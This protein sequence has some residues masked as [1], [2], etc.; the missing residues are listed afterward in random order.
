MPLTNDDVQMICNRFE[1]IL[2]WSQ[3]RFQNNF[4]TQK[5]SWRV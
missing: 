5:K 3:N 4:S 2:T 1:I